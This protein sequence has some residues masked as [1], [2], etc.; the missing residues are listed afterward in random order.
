MK[1]LTQIEAVNWCK[2]NQI[3]LDERD[4]PNLGKD[5]E[6]FDIPSDAGQRIAL[7]KGHLERYRNE[8]ELLIWIRD[9]GVWESAERPHIFYKFR[10][11]YGE[12]RTLEKA[13]AQLCSRDE[14]E[15]SLS[16]VTLAVLFLWDCFIV[17]KANGKN[18]F[19]SHDEYGMITSE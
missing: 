15:D 5:Y 16:I 12:Y 9:W 14:F 17:S 10:L 4:R 7:V 3:L 11:S 1:F 8:E 18:L 19:Y 6:R 2:N 13:P